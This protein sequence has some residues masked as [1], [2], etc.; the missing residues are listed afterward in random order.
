MPALRVREPSD[1]AVEAGRYSGQRRSFK[2]TANFTENKIVIE[3]LV[4][5][6][7][8]IGPFVLGASRGSI[9]LAVGHPN[10]V[11]KTTDSCS[12]PQEEWHYNTLG[13]RLNFSEEHDW[14]LGSISAS[15]R[16]AVINGVRFIGR[17]ITDLDTLCCSAGI[18]DLGPD[19]EYD[20][21]GSCYWS[22]SSGLMLWIESRHVVSLHIFLK[23]DAS[24]IQP[25]WPAMNEFPA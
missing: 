2:N 21:Y 16:H 14:R 1:Q 7:R 24:G 5:P 4:F 8:G 9:V 18:G 11:E 10:H 3:L 6:H 17:H 15:G 25:C 13:V 22:E 12:V 19:G 23:Y 20:E